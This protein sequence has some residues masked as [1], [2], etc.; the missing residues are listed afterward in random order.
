MPYADPEKRREAHRKSNAK[1]RTNPKLKARDAEYN[2]RY[3]KKRR[4]DPAYRQK[5]N[6][7]IQLGGTGWTPAMKEATSAEQGNRCM[8]CRQTPKPKKPQGGVGG[9]CADHA[10]TIPP[11]PRALLCHSCNAGLGL[12]KDSPELCRAAAEYLEA[13]A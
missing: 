4:E 10:H 6:L 5:N 2:R 12:F 7:Q 9:L 3:V 13:W 11:Q 8:I 1:R